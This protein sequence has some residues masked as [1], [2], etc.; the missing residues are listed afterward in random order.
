MTLLAPQSRDALEHWLAYQASLR[1]AATKTI[2]AYRRDVTQFLGFMA[3]HKNGDLDLK[4]IAIRDM[5]AWMAFERGRGLTPRSLARALSAVKS[6]YRFV[7][8]TRGIDATVVLSMRAPKF[9]AKLPRP[10]AAED[11]SEMLDTFDTGAKAD[12]IAA[13]DV[14]VATLLYGAG[15]RISEALGLTGGDLPLPEVLRITGKGGKTRLVPLLPI[16]RDAVAD[17]LRLCPHPM[18]AGRAVFRGVRGGDLSPRMVQKAMEQVRHA[19]GLPATAT[20]H[21][22][23]HSFAT[24]LLGAG[25]DLRTIQELLGHASLRATQTYTSIDTPRLIDVYDN[26]HPK[27]L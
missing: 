9:H 18:A 10:V 20:P 15:L 2:E 17:Y 19:L 23:R 1:N 6:F 12:W 3:Q 4:D 8:R 26:A 16:V 25:G 22:L 21:A 11:V 13:R 24:H 5:R 7:A 14:A 27:A